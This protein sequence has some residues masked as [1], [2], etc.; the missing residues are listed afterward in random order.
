[1]LHLQERRAVGAPLIGLIAA[2]AA[3]G[4]GQIREAVPNL[5]QSLS[6]TGQ[7]QRSPGS[8]SVTGSLRT[9][10][11]A[12]MAVTLSN[13]KVLIAGGLDNNNHAIASAELYDPTPARWSKTAGM[14]TARVQATMTLLQN[15][16]VL[17]AGGETATGLTA[18]AEIYNPSAHRWS[19]TGSMTTP[20]ANHT[21]TAA[22]TAQKFTILPVE[23]GRSP[24]ACLPRGRATPQRFL[25]PE[26][27]WLAAET[28]TSWTERPAAPKSTTQKAENGRPPD[29]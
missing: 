4:C 13:G 28:S 2:I 17:V 9:P 24:E 27:C 26:E 11:V 16:R 15:K 10:R 22:S 23:N 20:R 3:A 19:P 21:A 8:W 29:G 14:S 7:R 25:R 18:S 5:A 12:P 6:Q 1:M